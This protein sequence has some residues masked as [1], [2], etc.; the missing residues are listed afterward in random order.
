MRRQPVD[1]ERPVGIA[2]S[3][4]KRNEVN[5]QKARQEEDTGA[6]SGLD[7]HLLGTW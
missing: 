3:H 1:H 6:G 2:S 7:E 4:K 5:K